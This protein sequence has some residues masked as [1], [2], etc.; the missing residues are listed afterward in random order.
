M[1]MH[2]ANTIIKFSNKTTVVGLII[3]HDE[4][5][6]REEV[7][8]L[9]VWCQ[10]NNLSLKVGKTKELI[11]VYRKWRAEHALIHINGAVLERTKSFKV[12][13]V[14]ITKDLSQSKHSNTV[15]K[16]VQ[17]CLFPL[18]R[19]KGFGPSDPQKNLQLHH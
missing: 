18:R 1:A 19:L 7:R 5:A 14:H 17:Q 6:Y 11:V 16:R 15:V 9:A 3:D 10:N 2:N 13:C 12:L 4:T 8:Y